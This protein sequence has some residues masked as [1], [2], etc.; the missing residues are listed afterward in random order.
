MRI[1]WC[2]SQAGA[3]SLVALAALGAVALAG[4]SHD[5][6]DVGT[7]EREI[8][9]FVAR[10]YPAVKTGAVICPDDVDGKKGTKFEC[11]AEIEGQKLSIAVVMK[12]DEGNASFEPTQAV[13]DIRRAE[14]AMATDLGNQLQAELEVDCGDRDFL[15]ADPHDTFDC[16]LSDAEGNRVGLRVTVADVEGHVQY[17]TVEG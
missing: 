7:A 5:N 14:E 6:Y 12:D 15:V 17:E 16:T 10:T 3:R 8:G 9:R 13:L 1:S 4:C 2:S 11:A